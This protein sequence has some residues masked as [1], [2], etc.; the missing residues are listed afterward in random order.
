MD[1]QEFL[2]QESN[3]YGELVTVEEKLMI[4]LQQDKGCKYVFPPQ[5]MASLLEPYWNELT[6]HQKMSILDDW[7]WE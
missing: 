7:V 5:V 4:R 3:L 2:K 6:A 1:F